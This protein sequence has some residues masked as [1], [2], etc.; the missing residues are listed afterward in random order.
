MSKDYISI[1]QLAKRM[2]LDRSSV[3]KILV[4]D[5]VELVRIR[6]ADSANQLSL[7]ISIGDADRFLE[8]RRDAGFATATPASSSEHGFFYVIQL[9]PELD[10]RRIKFGFAGSVHQ[11]L[12]DHR[13]AAPTATLLISWKC[14][15]SWEKTVMDCLAS[16]R[17]NIIANEVYECEDFEAMIA[18]GNSLF[19]LLPEVNSTVPFSIASPLKG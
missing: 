16:V 19:A 17:C 13:T 1:K 8:R 3:R 15:R 11:R 4:R 14:R 10:P 7:A 6:T 2:E 18:I 5:G 12:Q 9:V